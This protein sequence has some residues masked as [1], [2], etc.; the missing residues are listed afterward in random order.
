MS[1]VVGGIGADTQLP[2]QVFV[3]KGPFED[4]MG[5]T[6]AMAVSKIIN[7][8][9]ERGRCPSKPVVGDD[10][11]VKRGL[12]EAIWENAIEACLKRD[13]RSRPDASGLVRILS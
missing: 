4:L 7:A 2:A 9:C 12:N 1:V 5:G 10:A 11:F 13:P 3:G 8:V 6:P